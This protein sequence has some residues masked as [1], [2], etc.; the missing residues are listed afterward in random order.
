MSNKSRII[1]ISGKSGCG[2]T[3]VSS[4][5][6]RELGFTLVNYTFRSLADDLGISFQELAKLAQEDDRY[7]RMLDER[8]VA[9]AHSG[10]CVLGSRLA[11]WLVKDADLTVYL[12]ASLETR[13]AR[14]M[15][16]EGEDLQRKLEETRK[17]DERDSERYLRIYGIDTSDYRWADLVIDTDRCDQFEAASQIVAAYRERSGKTFT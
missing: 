2:N 13:A 4:L 16:R 14:I 3:T 9:M 8:Q 7:D 17:R 15:K 10:S 6:A 1:A 11:I 12:D 5:V